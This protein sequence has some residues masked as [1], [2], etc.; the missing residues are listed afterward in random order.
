MCPK[1]VTIVFE[2]KKFKLFKIIYFE[3]NF[4][5]IKFRECLRILII[6][7]FSRI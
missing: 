7:K 6:L 1:I 2:L 3:S 4:N 5:G